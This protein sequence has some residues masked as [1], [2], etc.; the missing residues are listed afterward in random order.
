VYDDEIKRDTHWKIGSLTHHKGV[1]P[2]C[3]PKKDLSEIRS[4]DQYEEEIELSELD[5]IGEKAASNLKRAGITT[6]ETVERLPDDRILNV[7]WVGERALTSL[8]ERANCV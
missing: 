3:N 6:V 2:R 4:S 8:K 5:G 7:S 1:C